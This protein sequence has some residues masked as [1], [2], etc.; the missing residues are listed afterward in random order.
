[1]SF[2]DLICSPHEGTSWFD[3]AIRE[4]K[5]GLGFTH[6]NPPVGCVIVK[7]EQ[8]IGTGYHLKYG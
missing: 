5:K 3:E 2:Y 4:A 6:P 8:L 1:M 7:E